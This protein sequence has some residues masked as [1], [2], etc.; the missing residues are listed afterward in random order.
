M[1]FF[2][3]FLYV[4][5]SWHW[6]GLVTFGMSCYI[7][8]LLYISSC[9][10]KKKINGQMGE[11]RIWINGWCRVVLFTCTFPGFFFFPYFC[12][13]HEGRE[14]IMFRGILAPFLVTISLGQ[15]LQTNIIIM[16]IKVRE[17]KIHKI[18]LMLC[19]IR[20]RWN[21]PAATENICLRS[22]QTL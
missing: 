9:K 2:V 16:M 4:K 21:G 20:D 3:L 6:N 7:S 11:E 17:K 12:P 1:L 15:D 18:V 13:S 14:E 5:M 10:K 19:K 22:N 8:N